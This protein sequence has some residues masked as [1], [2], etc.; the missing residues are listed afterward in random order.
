[1]EDSKKTKGQL[2]KELTHL[3]KRNTEL[4]AAEG[5]HNRKEEALRESAEKFRLVFENAFDGISIFKEF[6]DPDDPDNRRL[7]ECNTSYAEMAGRSREELLRIGRTTGLAK[8]LSP[9]NLPSIVKSV[10]F[11]GMFSWLRPDGKDNIIEYTA[12][13]IV[14]KGKKFTIGID[15]DITERVR[16]EE[17]LRRTQAELEQRVKERTAELEDINDKLQK[18]IAERKRIERELYHSR[19]MLQ[20][21]L[22]TIPQC[23]FWK[24]RNFL[25]LGCNKSFAKDAGHKNPIELMGKNDFELRWK[26]VA[27]LYRDDDKLV[28]ETDIPKL[29]FEESRITPEGNQLWIKTSKVPLHDK[30]GK[31]IG[32]LGIY[33]DIT[34]RKKAEGA[35]QRERNLLRT[36][37]IIYLT[38]FMLKILPAENN[39]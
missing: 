25:Y 38:R 13:P 4:E 34:E 2:L 26:E 37:L 35:L 30:D 27:Q 16:T 7:I 39:C 8:P 20:L 9:H 36:L 14:I 21:V 33:E 10:S 23:V 5:E 1:M 12:V 29:D 17:T 3:R 24:D 28:M 32:V 11:H 22:D 6:E 15:R 18:E 31:V 19:Q